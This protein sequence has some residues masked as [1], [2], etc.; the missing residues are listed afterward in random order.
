MTLTA[1]PENQL[2]GS[3]TEAALF[4]RIRGELLRRGSKAVLKMGPHVPLENAMY[5]DCL[6]CPSI[7]EAPVITIELKAARY[8][9][10]FSLS[11]PEKCFSRA[12]WVVID[13]TWG[14]WS[15][16]MAVAREHLSLKVEPGG[17]RYWVCEPPFESHVT[18][19]V[20]IDDIQRAIGEV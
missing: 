9:D 11:D 1:S 2:L 16:P 17:K 14:I 20:V 3:T 4:E 5:G 19:S 12:K 13:G 7:A 6:C 8:I 10:T 18:L 15:I